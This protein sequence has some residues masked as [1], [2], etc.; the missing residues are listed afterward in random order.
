MAAEHA[1]LRGTT[2]GRQAGGRRPPRSSA[3]TNVSSTNIVRGKR[4]LSQLK[5]Q[6]KPAADDQ[7]RSENGMDRPCSRPEPLRE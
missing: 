6:S 1:Y 4:W 3:L 2:K 5:P 7:Q